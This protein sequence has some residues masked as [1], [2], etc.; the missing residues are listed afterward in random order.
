M[1][2]TKPTKATF[3]SFVSDV[4]ELF[5]LRAALTFE[6]GFDRQ[7]F[8][9]HLFACLC[10]PI[11]ASYSRTTNADRGTNATTKPNPCGIRDAL[12]AS[13]RDI[14]FRYSDT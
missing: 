1:L 10:D 7:G 6:K 3:V 14:L 13:E 11:S 9:T 12:N 2:L 8:K 4:M 5:G